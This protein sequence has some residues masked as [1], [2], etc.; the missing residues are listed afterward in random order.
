ME[1]LVF[2]NPDIL[3]DSLA[4]E[5]SKKLQLEGISFR[6][7]EDPQRL[8]EMEG[9]IVIMD[10]AKGVKRPVVLED[11]SKIE[12]RGISSLHDFDLGFVLKLRAGLGRKGKIRIIALPKGK[13]YSDIKDD[14]KSIIRGLRS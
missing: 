13:S 4:P 10:V 12:K 1:I 9:D 2:G 5:I 11:V 6:H 3:E 7:L 8:L 14:V